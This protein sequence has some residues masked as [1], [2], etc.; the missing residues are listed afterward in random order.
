MTFEKQDPCFTFV[1]IS[2]LFLDRHYWE[3]VLESNNPSV[4][5][6]QLRKEIAGREAFPSGAV[7]ISLRWRVNKG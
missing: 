5:K 7:L 2:F 1:I 3:E 6:Q 4:R